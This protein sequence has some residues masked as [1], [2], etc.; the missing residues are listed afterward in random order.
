MDIA[1]QLNDDEL[2]S[3]LFDDELI[4]LINSSSCIKKH[5]LPE[6]KKEDGREVLEQRYL[7][8]RFYACNSI[9]KGLRNFTEFKPG[10]TYH[11]Y[12]NRKRFY[13]L[14]RVRTNWEKKT[15]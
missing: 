2:I 1:S 13:I 8:C 3:Q 7:R 9:V 6:A 5:I 11:I 14:A 4:D 12:C 15:I 10:K